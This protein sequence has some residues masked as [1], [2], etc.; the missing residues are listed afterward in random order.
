MQNLRPARL[1][2]WRARLSAC[3]IGAGAKSFDWG[4]WDCAVFIADAVQAQTGV[5]I[6]HDGR[7]CYTTKTGALRL[8][9]RKV[10]TLGGYVARAGAPVE[11]P[12]LG[13]V[14]LFRGP[15]GETCGIWTPSGIRAV[16]QSGLITCGLDLA[17]SVHGV[18]L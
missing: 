3:L 17:I 12:A 10:G 6:M 13:D 11:R 2:D 1:P 16:S 8:I 7:G 5:D 14:A 9:K 4:P 15:E 18:G